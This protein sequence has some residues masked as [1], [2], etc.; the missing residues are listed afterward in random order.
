METS[1]CQTVLYLKFDVSLTTA[2]FQIESGNEY[3]FL[4]WVVR[5][6]ITLHVIFSRE[7]FFYPIINFYIY[8]Y[9]LLFKTSKVRILKSVITCSETGLQTVKAKTGLFTCPYSCFS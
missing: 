9:T 6:P 7:L 2:F 5:F 1:W 3:T 4:V 8:I